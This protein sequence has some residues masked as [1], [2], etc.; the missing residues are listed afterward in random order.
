MKI[1]IFSSR[2]IGKQ[3]S[4]LRMGQTYYAIAVSTISTI[5]LIVIAFEFEMW[6]LLVLFPI[7]LFSAFLVGYYMDIKDVTTQDVLKT[8]EIGHRFL[9]TSDFKVQEFQ[10]LL[11]KV[12][13][14]SF[15]DIKDN[16]NINFD[17]LT[18][19]YEKYLKKWKS[20]N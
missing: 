15:Q 5:S 11:V 1:K 10:L 20:T 19:E 8:N 2:F 3:L 7:L 4:R 9:L 6:V 16:K 17:Y 14:K 12:I 18:E 13:M